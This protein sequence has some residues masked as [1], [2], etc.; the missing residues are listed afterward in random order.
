VIFVAGGASLNFF[1]KTAYMLLPSEDNEPLSV[2]TTWTS[3]MLVIGSF[4][5][6]AIPPSLQCSNWRVISRQ[7]SKVFAMICFPALCD[8]FI[9]GARFTALIFLPPAVVAIVKASVQLVVLAFINSCRGKPLTSVM[10]SALC[11][12]LLGD[13]VVVIADLIQSDMD[14]NGG[15]STRMLG[16]V[17]VCA[18]GAF[19][20]VRNSIEEW[21]LQDC[22]I[23]SGVL[24]M[25][26]SWI[27]V[28]FSIF[29]GLTIYLVSTLDQDSLS[30]STA[31]KVLG[32]PGFVPCFAS[33]MVAT[34]MTD[35]GK[36]KVM[37]YGSA[38]LAKIIAI[39]SPFGTWLICLVVYY[40]TFPGI[41]P[42]KIV[43]G[44]GWLTLSSTI[45]LFGMAIIIAST[46]I[47][48]TAKKPS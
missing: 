1:G 41:G 30:L 6:C 8:V 34:Y 26:E 31:W 16:L 20:A 4:L 33:F 32:I 46:V 7:N 13:C 22:A 44:E 36:F 2:L 14:D 15:T 17:I 19:G 5:A 35:A 18:S 27:S 45:R 10:W 42:D 37:Y 12:A 24:L 29:A 25:M 28:T 23:P 11:C 9:T 3:V 38:M 40:A 21:L 48:T 43:L 39:L 47:F